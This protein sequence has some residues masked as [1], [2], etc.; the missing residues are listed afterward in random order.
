M[1]AVAADRTFA[2]WVALETRRR[3]QERSDRIE[4]LLAEAV[5]L[6]DYSKIDRL[7]VVDQ[8]G[9]HPAVASLLE[10]R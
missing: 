1:S 3:M 5:A 9:C 10:G 7:T 2:E 6:S 4:R 8:H